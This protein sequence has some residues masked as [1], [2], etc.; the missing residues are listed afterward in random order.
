MNVITIPGDI[1]ADILWLLEEHLPDVVAHAFNLRTPEAEVDGSLWVQ[2]QSGLQSKFFVTQRNHVL[3]EAKAE[4]E[5][6]EEEERK[7]T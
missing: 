7:S 1:S 3:E 2:G 5:E 6:K 4:E